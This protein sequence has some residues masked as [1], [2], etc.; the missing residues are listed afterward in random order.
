MVFSMNN[1]LK[2]ERLLE[3]RKRILL[4]MDKLNNE[5]NEIG[6]DAEDMIPGH[7][8]G[9]EWWAKM[10]QYE[11]LKRQIK[12]IGKELTELGYKYG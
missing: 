10:N 8:E 2:I 4:W 7:D 5:M 1:N 11:I 3:Q 9:A 6:T 12:E